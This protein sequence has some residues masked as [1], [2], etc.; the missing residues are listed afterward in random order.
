MSLNAYSLALLVLSCGLLGNALASGLALERALRAA[1]RDSDVVM[2]SIDG[3]CPGVQAIADGELGA[4]SMQFPLRMASLGIEAIAAFAADGTVP[5]P[6]EG[7][8]IFDT[9]V[10]L[11]TDEP[12]EGVPS[13]TS[14]EALEQCW[15]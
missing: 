3:G 5:E 14:A 4:T 13:I 10:E 2:V 11:V 6:T 15:G 12:V 1:G 7:L 8:D 9:G